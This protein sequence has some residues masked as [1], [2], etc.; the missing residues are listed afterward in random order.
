M[1]INTELGVY[2]ESPVYATMIHEGFDKRIMSKAYRVVLNEK[3]NVEWITLEHGKE[4]RYSKE[5]ETSFWK[6]FSAG[7][8]NIFVPESQL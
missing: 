5:P 4:V 7:F 3:N 2:F 8:M 1:A 6:R